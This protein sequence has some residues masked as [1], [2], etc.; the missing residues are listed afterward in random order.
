M[1]ASPRF[2]D[3]ALIGIKMAVPERRA[4]LKEIQLLWNFGDEPVRRARYYDRDS[5]GHR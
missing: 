2:S 4:F 3:G 5:Q 1:V